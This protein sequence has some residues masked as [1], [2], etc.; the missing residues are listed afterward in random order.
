MLISPMYIFAKLFIMLG[1]RPDLAAIVQKSQ[2]PPL[3]PA[4]SR[5]D[6]GPTP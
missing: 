2:Q 1:L 4:E 3:Y 6:V 5:A